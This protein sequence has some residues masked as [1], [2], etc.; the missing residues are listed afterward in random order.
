[1]DRTTTITSNGSKWAGEPPDSVETLLAVLARHTLDPRFETFGNF[2]QREAAGVSFFGNFLDL[3]HVFNITT[4]DPAV[5]KP[6]VRAIRRNQRRPDYQRCRPMA[7]F[8]THGREVKAGPF[9]SPKEARDFIASAQPERVHVALARDG[10]RIVRRY[11]DG[12]AAGLE[13]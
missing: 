3:S 9:P 7:C 10:W 2:V 13:S 1:M 5:W 6:L 11:G 4:N 8:V 12:R